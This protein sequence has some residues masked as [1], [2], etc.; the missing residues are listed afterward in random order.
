MATSRKGLDF[1]FSFFESSASTITKQFLL[2]GNWTLQ[3]L[4]LCK[5]RFG[6]EF[7]DVFGSLFCSASG[8]FISFNKYQHT[9]CTQQ[10]P[11]S[12]EERKTRLRCQIQ[13]M[14]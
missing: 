7:E 5:E 9:L 1:F 12:L 3:Q 6:A 13:G 4:G 10:N 2:R 14:K 11:P 8:S